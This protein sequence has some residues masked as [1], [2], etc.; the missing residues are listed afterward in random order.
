MGLS[1]FFPMVLSVHRC[2]RPVEMQ[3]LLWLKVLHFIF[4]AVSCT[5]LPAAMMNLKCVS[6]DML[7]CVMKEYEKD[8]FL[9]NYS[10]AFS[11]ITFFH[12][13]CCK[14]FLSLQGSL[15]VCATGRVLELPQVWLFLPCIVFFLLSQF[16]L[17]PVTHLVPSWSPENR[18][19]LSALRNWELELYVFVFWKYFRPNFY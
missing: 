3:I 19:L 5:S 16:C 14:I 2:F 7:V 6:N 4:A 13:L 12:C 9:S 17:F 1:V 10:E 11:H 18:K 8:T 15:G